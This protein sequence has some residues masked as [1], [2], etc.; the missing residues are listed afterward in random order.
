MVRALGS[1]YC[2]VLECGNVVRKVKGGGGGFTCHDQAS[3]VCW[4]KAMLYLTW[5]DFY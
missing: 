1:N 3:S 2:Y 5:A 4:K